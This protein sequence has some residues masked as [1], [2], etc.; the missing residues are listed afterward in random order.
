MGFLE[1]LQSRKKKIKDEGVFVLPP[2]LFSLY[3]LM[4]YKEKSFYSLVHKLSI[5]P[6]LILS[7]VVQILTYL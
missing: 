6:V 4:K 7:F 1:S 5:S 3:L 2:F